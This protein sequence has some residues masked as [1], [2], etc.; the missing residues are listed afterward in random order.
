MSNKK[1]FNQFLTI[2]SGELISSIGSGMTAFALSIYVFNQTGSASSVGLVIL[3]AFLPS[4]LLS[5]FAGVLADRYD[6]RLLMII[7]DGF[8]AFGLVFMLLCYMMGGLHLWQICLGV[9]FSSI[10]TSLLEPSYRAT[11][12]DLLTEEEFAKASGL[13]QMAGAS[14][15]LISPIISGFIMSVSGIQLILL[16]DISTFLVTLTTILLVRKSIDSHHT[17]KQH[18]SFKADFNEGMQELTA[19]KGIMNLIILISLV[20]FF[21]GCIQTLNAPMLLPLIDDKALGILMSVSSIGLLLGSLFIG[22]F[23]APKQNVKMVV[24]GFIFMG[25]GMILF[26][27]F[28]NIV[29][30]TFS[31]FILFSSI[32]FIN[33]GLDVLIRTNIPNE[34]QGRVW[35]LISI[36]SQLGYLVAYGIVGI[37]AD[38]IFLPLLMPGGSLASS[39]GT[40]IGVGNGRGIGLMFI[41]SGIFVIMLAILIAISKPIKALEVKHN[42]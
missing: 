28:V 1:S 33:T 3:L 21:I 38:K 42:V 24:F 18:S 31:C 8:S 26:G 23:G 11:I 25:I 35:G 34:K 12:S 4:V 9:S 7:G 13:V 37:L 6:R 15:F 14:K 2:W 19:K 30:I 36:I 41:I 39:I 16:I 5:P 17:L 40:I 29:L 10:F 32:P 20:T 27:Y 22:L